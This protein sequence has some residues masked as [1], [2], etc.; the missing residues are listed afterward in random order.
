MVYVQGMQYDLILLPEPMQHIQET[1]GIRASGKADQHGI[2]LC[3]KAVF[4]NG[5][6][7]FFDK[8]VCFLQGHVVSL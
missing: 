2:A 1:G 4:V 6:F 3:K 8:I 5:L 7:C